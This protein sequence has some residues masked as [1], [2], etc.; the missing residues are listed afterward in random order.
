MTVQAMGS[1]E[2]R[3]CHSGLIWGFGWAA[4]APEPGPTALSAVLQTAIIDF[5]SF[6][7]I[8]PQSTKSCLFFKVLLRFGYDMSP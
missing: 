6:I 4:T 5:S 8:E 1:R 2:P 7:E 3:H